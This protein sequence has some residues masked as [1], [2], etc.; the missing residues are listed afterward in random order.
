MARCP[1]CVNVG[2]PGHLGPCPVCGGSQ[3]VADLVQDP[4]CKVCGPKGLS[5]VVIGT[6]T[7][8]VPC[9]TCSKPAPTLQSTQTVVNP[10]GTVT[11]HR[12][13]LCP[14]CKGTGYDPHRTGK[15]SCGVCL[16][17]GYDKSQLQ[18]AT[19]HTVNGVSA[20]G[21][22]T[23]PMPQDLQITIWL[24]QAEKAAIYAGQLGA[25]ADQCLNDQDP[26][27]AN[28]RVAQM[29]QQTQLAA[30]LTARAMLHRWTQ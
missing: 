8:L 1:N 24:D 11:M 19:G 26:N 3:Q 21:V 28:I 29:Q 4:A 18:A 5:T 22:T 23:Q 20:N 13:P 2:R 16:G 7:C 25:E 14:H 30:T 10:N 6:E 27:R 12:F 9:H 17:T 15:Y